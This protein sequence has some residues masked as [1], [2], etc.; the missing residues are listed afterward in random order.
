[1][2]RAAVVSFIKGLFWPLSRK[3][4][5]ALAVLAFLVWLGCVLVGA[6]LD[7]IKVIKSNRADQ[8]SERVVNE[9]LNQAAAHEANANAAS[10]NRQVDEAR[11]QDAARD[12]EQAAVNSNL[13]LAPTRAAQRHYEKVRR[14][15]PATATPVLNDDQLCTELTKRG[16]DCQ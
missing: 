15:D 11:A 2:N 16:F 3:T 9:Q 12:K 13:T 7:T 4:L 10:V 8:K 6:G 5:Y 14:H 1:M